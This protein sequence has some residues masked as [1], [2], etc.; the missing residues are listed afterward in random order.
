MTKLNIVRVQ[1]CHLLILTL[2]ESLRIERPAHA[3]RTA[4]G[5]WCRACSAGHRLSHGANK[6]N[7]S[8][9][10]RAQPAIF[11]PLLSSES[12]G[13]ALKVRRPSSWSCWVDLCHS[14]FEA[15]L[16]NNGVDQKRSI[17]AV[18]QTNLIRRWSRLSLFL[19][20]TSVFIIPGV[21]S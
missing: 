17:K 14:P 10:L 12:Q 13:R 6:Q 2:I 11:S 21:N 7:C 1:T 15:V 5:V 18:T 9:R 20:R 19:Y 16:T 8:R 3:L 4:G